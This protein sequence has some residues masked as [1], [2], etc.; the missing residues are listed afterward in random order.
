MSDDEATAALVERA[1]IVRLGERHLAA[2]Q[3]AARGH[4]HTLAGDA[5]A[6]AR[7]VEAL[8]EAIEAGEQHPGVGT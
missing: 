1:R 4:N 6:A 5:R 8:L 7:A 3:Q 2:H